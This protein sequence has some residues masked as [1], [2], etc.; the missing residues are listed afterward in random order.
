MKKTGLL[1]VSIIVIIGSVWAILGRYYQPT[2]KVRPPEL[3]AV[4]T[5]AAEEV[6]KLAPAAGKVVLVVC[7]GPVEM[8][9]M[10]MIVESFQQ[11]FPG[12]VTERIAVKNFVDRTA[13]TQELLGLLEKQAEVDVVVTIGGAGFLDESALVNSSQSLPRL[14]PVLSFLPVQ[15]KALLAAQRVPFG[16]MPNP[17]AEPPERK[18]QTAHEWFDTA[19]VIVTPQTPAIE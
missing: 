19:F 1:V 16:I 9:G 13:A 7:H 5:V 10:E 6:R 3:M 14:V 12:T 18:P 11:A 15:L 2:Q 17:K 4:G 8:L